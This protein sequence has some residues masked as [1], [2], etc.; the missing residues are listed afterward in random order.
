MHKVYALCLQLDILLR[1][2]NCS[3]PAFQMYA[4]PDEGLRADEYR[5]TDRY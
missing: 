3:Q 4:E 1:H 2:V 5:E